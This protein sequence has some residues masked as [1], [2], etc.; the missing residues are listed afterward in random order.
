MT[1]Q[2][3]STTDI[4]I[5]YNDTGKQILIQEDWYEYRKTVLI[6]KIGTNTR[7]GAFRKTV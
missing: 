7:N 2:V 1:C 4:T 3:I 6:W 5:V